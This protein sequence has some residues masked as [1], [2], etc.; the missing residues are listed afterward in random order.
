MAWKKS[1]KETINYIKEKKKEWAEINSEFNKIDIIS[2]GG[3]DSTAQ[4]IEIWKNNS[5]AH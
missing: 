4:D 2:K 1:E 3:S 5:P